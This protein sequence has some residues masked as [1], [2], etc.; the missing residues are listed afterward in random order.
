MMLK[1]SFLDG[2]GQSVEMSL[3]SLEN[4]P[5]MVSGALPKT[6]EKFKQIKTLHFRVWSEF[7]TWDMVLCSERVA[8]AR[9]SGVDA[10]AP[11]AWLDD[12]GATPTRARAGSSCRRSS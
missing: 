1:A 3:K 4:P 8:H 10:N 5:K 12:D 6:H 9:S 11:Y 7:V 2:S